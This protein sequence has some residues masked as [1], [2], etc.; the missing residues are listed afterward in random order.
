MLPEHRT[1]QILPTHRHRPVQAVAARTQNLPGV[2]VWAPLFSIFP[3]TSV[4]WVLRKGLVNAWVIVCRTRGRP[5]C[6]QSSSAY[7]AQ[8]HSCRRPFPDPFNSEGNQGRVM[9]PTSH[10]LAAWGPLLQQETD[11]QGSPLSP[12]S[13]VVQA[14]SGCVQIA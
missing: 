9:T 4:Q 5:H 12:W 2:E 3:G 14:G 6:P 7:S 1:G 10:D 8:S 13:S 11:F